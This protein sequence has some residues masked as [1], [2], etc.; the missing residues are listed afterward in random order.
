[1][2]FRINRVFAVATVITAL[3]IAWPAFAQTRAHEAWPTTA[4]GII[5]GVVKDATGQPIKGAKVTMES[6]E[7]I[8]TKFETK[9]GKK[10]DYAQV[11]LPTGPYRVTVE[12]DRMSQTQMAH[13]WVRDST[14]ANFV[15]A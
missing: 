3:A 15:L 14:T 5:Q 1:M 11:G 12:K 2:T 13:V 8:P 6:T 10:G 7:G 4:P 9:T